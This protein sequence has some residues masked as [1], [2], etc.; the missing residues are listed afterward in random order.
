MGIFY[1]RPAMTPI[2]KKTIK[3]GNAFFYC[4]VTAILLAIFSF[5]YSPRP[6][7]ASRIYNPARACFSNLKVLEGAVELYIMEN[8]SSVNSI[9]DLVK[10]GYIKV[11]PVCRSRDNSEDT[12]LLEQPLTNSNLSQFFKIVKCLNHGHFLVDKNMFEKQL[13]IVVEY[14]AERQK[15]FG[16]IAGVLS[17]LI[18]WQSIILWRKLSC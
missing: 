18:L 11:K 6:A 17:L 7:F 12:Y 15:F 10:S 4:A 14:R 13:D 1:E 16:A 2:V 9:D 3:P 8:N 5:F